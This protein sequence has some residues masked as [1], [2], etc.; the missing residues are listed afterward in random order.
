MPNGGKVAIFGPHPM[1]SIA[2]EALT[3]EGGGDALSTDALA[4]FPSYGGGKS[5]EPDS[6]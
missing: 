4:I 3:A 6:N 2:V 1:L 5:P